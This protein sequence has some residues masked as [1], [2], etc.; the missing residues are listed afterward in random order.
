MD[1]SIVQ[2]AIKKLAKQASETARQNSIAA[3][4]RFSGVYTND[5]LQK[6]EREA[7]LNAMDRIRA[8]SLI[9]GMF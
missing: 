6:A 8:K 5:G 4:M 2:E 3:S 9:G 1:N 7:E